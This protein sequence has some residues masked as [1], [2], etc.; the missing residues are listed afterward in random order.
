MVKWPNDGIMTIII[1]LEKPKVLLLE[2]HIFRKFVG[3][4]NFVVELFVFF[5]IIG[6]FMK[7]LTIFCSQLLFQ[8]IG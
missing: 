6:L 2:V 1:L 5:N 8:M 3:F 4:S 7:K